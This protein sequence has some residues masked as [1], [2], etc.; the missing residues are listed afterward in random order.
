MRNA[1]IALLA[2]GILAGAYRALRRPSA[3]TDG[4]PLRLLNVSYDATGELY[5]EYNAAF[6]AHREARAGQRPT[7]AQSHGG[8]GKQARGIIDGL[9]A[10]VATLALA[11]DIDALHDRAHL[12]PAG[13]QGRLPDHSAPYTST[14]VFVVRRGNP[15][16]IKDWDDLVKPGIVVVTANPK[17]SG[18]ARWNYLAAWGYALKRPGGDEAMARQFVTDLYRNVPVLDSGAR[19]ATTTFGQRGI[20]DVLITWE[21][22]AH[23]LVERLGADRFETVIPSRSILAEPSVV[24]VD[25]YVDRHGTRALATAYLEHLY[26][27]EGQEIV[28]RHHFRPRLAAVAE[29]YGD[30][31]PQISLFTVDDTFGGWKAAQATHFA[32]GGTFDRIYAA[33]R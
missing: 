23:L 25:T 18:G 27:K 15:R 12:V 26:S 20:G 10:D 32:D 7:I 19:G 33:G 22:E 28:A 11:F 24:V 21:N 3:I 16:G 30:R 1:L 5:R 8:S 14:I 4:E 29:R 6:A 13:W 9:E 2:A 17:T 31:F